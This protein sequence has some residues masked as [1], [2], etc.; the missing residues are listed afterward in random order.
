MRTPTKPAEATSPAA[1][2]ARG[3]A[4]SLTLDALRRQA[5]Q[6]SPPALR[7]GV[8]PAGGAGGVDESGEPD[9]D[10]DSNPDPD[11]DQNPDPDPNP[12]PKPV[13]DP[14]SDPKSR[15]GSKPGP[16]ATTGSESRS[17]P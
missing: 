11:P 1:H 8:D 16:G 17:E 4:A 2:S 7:R 15:P 6:G 14:N 9:T 3:R 5:G 10:S 13:M 12:D